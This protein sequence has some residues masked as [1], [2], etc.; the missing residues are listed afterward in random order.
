MRR[1]V[2]LYFIAQEQ[3]KHTILLEGATFSSYYLGNMWSGAPS[4]L[5]G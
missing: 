2:L 4:V 5:L 3:S 1:I